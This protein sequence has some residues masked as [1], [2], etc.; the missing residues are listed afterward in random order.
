LTSSERHQLKDEIIRRSDR[1]TVSGFL[2]EVKEAA[3]RT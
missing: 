2:F 1:D 3:K